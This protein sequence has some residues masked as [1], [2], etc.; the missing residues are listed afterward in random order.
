M[1]IRERMFLMQSTLLVRCKATACF[2]CLST[3]YYTVLV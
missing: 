3:A 1:E 2:G